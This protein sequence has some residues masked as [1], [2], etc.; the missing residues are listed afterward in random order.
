MRLSLATAAC[1][2]SFALLAGCSGSPQGTALPGGPSTGS[3][4][5]QIPPQHQVISHNSLPH[6]K[7]NIIKAL[8]MQ[9]AGKL[10]SPVSKEALKKIIKAMET[11]K[12]PHWKYNH[13]APAH[14]GAWALNEAFGYMLGLKP[15]LKKTTTAVDLTSNGCEEPV[16]AKEDANNNVWVGC[17][18]DGSFEGPVAQQYNSVGRLLNS[19]DTGT[20]SACNPSWYYCFNEADGFDEGQSSN[21]VWVTQTQGELYYCPTS[22]DTCYED[23]TAGLYNFPLGSPSASP[24]FINLYGT[25]VGGYPIYA[26]G[27]ADVDSSN[28]VYF[29]YEA[30]TY[31]YESYCFEVATGLAEYTS[32][33]SVVGLLPAG[34][35][36]FW[37]GVY[38]S[39][40]G[41]VLNVID[42]DSRENSQY[43]LPFTPSSAPFNI[44]GP[45]ATNLFGLGDPIQGTFNST[46]SKMAVGD[47]YGWIDSGVVSTNTWKGVGN[48]N[49]TDGCFGTTYQP[50]DRGA[51]AA[52]HR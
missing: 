10:A 50:S 25:E 19:Y 46:S 18:Y 40:G 41:T 38:V 11:Q 1:V 45:T 34:S 9:L 15:N 12:R 31:F 36:G 17:A 16:T 5:H 23:L 4:S 49:C 14:I 33:G 37:G 28:N 29:T 52:R 13:V 44:L 6:G 47:A 51:T 26:V 42:Q 35:I 22:F 24:T 3:A 27:Y 39:G 30:C 21:K 32:G 7:M 20:G 43:S 2:V 8:K 48:I